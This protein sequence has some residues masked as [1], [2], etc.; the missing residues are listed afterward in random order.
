MLHFYAYTTGTSSLQKSVTNWSLP[1]S[2]TMNTE[3]P[4]VLRSHNT[5][6]KHGFVLQ[7]KIYY[8]R[9]VSKNESWKFSFLL[10]VQV[11]Y[12]SLTED[13]DTEFSLTR[14]DIQSM[15]YFSGNKSFQN[16]Y[17]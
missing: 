14:F 16:V 4:M 13:P 3:F 10:K 5:N 12:T 7:F 15:G 6:K 1:P 17:V 8:L 9:S 2:E 11:C